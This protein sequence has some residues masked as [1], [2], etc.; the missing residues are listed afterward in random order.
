MGD[1]QEQRIIHEYRN[2]PNSRPVRPECVTTYLAMAEEGLIELKPGEFE[3]YK[4]RLDYLTRSPDQKNTETE[5]PE[6]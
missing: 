2:D 6:L 1:E 3:Y 4:K 5:E